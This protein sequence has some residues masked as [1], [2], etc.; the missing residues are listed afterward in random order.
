MFKE[1]YYSILA[2][3]TSLLAA[4]LSVV[5]LPKILGEIDYGYFQLYL[6]YLSFAGIL[7]WGWNDGIYLR[8]GGRSYRSLKK[9]IIGAQLYLLLFFTIIQALVISLLIANQFPTKYITALILVGSI[10]SNTQ[11]CLASIRLT[12][13]GAK[14][15]AFPIIIG[16]GLY[17]VLLVFGFMFQVTDCLL[18]I[19]AEFL[20]RLVQLLVAVFSSYEIFKSISINKRIII[21]TL[22]NMKLGLKIMIAS[23]SG[24]LILGITRYGISECWPIDVFGKIS[25]ILNV[26]AFFTAI[27][28][29]LGLAIFPHLKNIDIRMMGKVYADLKSILMFIV[30]FLLLIF[31]PLKYIIS[32]W[33][34]TY[35]S[36]FSYM[37]IIF[38]VFL[39]D[40]RIS[41][42]INSY[43][44]SLR[45]ENILLS[46]NMFVALFGVIYTYVSVV[47]IGSLFWT[48]MGI[49]IMQ[50]IRCFLAERFLARRLSI[51]VKLDSI[52]DVLMIT[53]FVTFGFWEKDILLFCSCISLLILYAYIKKD[54]LIRFKQKLIR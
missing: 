13:F 11:S 18:M 14:E 43:L 26:P 37:A 2:S 42:L 1:A 54:I 39:I 9:N 27:T 23:I 6:F 47:L 50:I 31:F 35:V 22:L 19:F 5:V 46:I 4:A 3:I 45:M 12:T 17:A 33:L 25:L 16:R 10:C 29:A 24:M 36:Y 15:Y 51:K 49:I 38:P 20:S 7:L 44:K 30:S 41:L 52:I 8:Y 28:N 32:I 34:P 40:T 53:N 21:A 48:I